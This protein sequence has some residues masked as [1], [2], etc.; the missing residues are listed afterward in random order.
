MNETMGPAVGYDKPVPEKD[1]L[2]LLTN[3]LSEKRRLSTVI[4][5]LNSSLQD[6]SVGY[7]QVEQTIQELYGEFEKETNIDNMP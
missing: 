2:Q 6:A 1:V 7:K 5:G 3:A 4:R